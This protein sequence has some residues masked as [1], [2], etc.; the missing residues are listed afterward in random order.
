MVIVT[1]SLSFQQSSPSHVKWQRHRNIIWFNPPYSRT[2]ITSV[3][4]K[5]LQLTNLHFPP[6]SKFHKIFNRNNVKVSYCCTQNVGNIIKSRNKKLINSSN[7]HAQPCNCTKKEDCPLEEKCRTENIIYKCI[8]STSGHPDNVYIGTVEGDFKKRYYN[9][10]SSFKNETQMNKTILAKYFWEQ[11]QRHNITPTLK[12]YIVKSVP[13]YSNI[14][15][16]CMLCLHER[17]EILTYSW[18]IKQKIRTCF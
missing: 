13:S 9:H 17:F 5:F 12:R 4:K 16:S 1:F 10:V 8:V 14:T 2:V 6:S 7:H 11:K 15:K 18:A 3:A